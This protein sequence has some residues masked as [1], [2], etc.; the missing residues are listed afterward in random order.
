MS[1]GI[2]HF[3]FG[4]GATTAVLMATKLDK[5]IKNT[6]PIRVAGGIV[7]MLPDAGKLIPSLDFFHDN[8]V[9]DIFWLHRFLDNK[10]DPQDTALNSFWLIVFMLAILGIFWMKNRRNINENS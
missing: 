8:W 6:E 5:K 7:A 10:F 4:V 3:A 9:A 1:M 2:G